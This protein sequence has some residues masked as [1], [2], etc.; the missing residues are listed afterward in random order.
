MNPTAL[1]P[2]CNLLR[3]STEL[4]QISSM[5]I[6]CFPCPWR[7]KQLSNRIKTTTRPCQIIQIVKLIA[8]NIQFE[9]FGIKRLMLIS[10]LR[11]TPMREV[12]SATSKPNHIGEPQIERNMEDGR[13]N[14]EHHNYSAACQALTYGPDHT[15]AP[16]E[17]RKQCRQNS[18]HNHL[19]HT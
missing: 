10:L 1:Q 5:S 4:G 13:I 9:I 2:A 17:R 11:V 8:N 19:L 7:D 6:Q 18:K 14:N 15:T 16:L 3:L 12:I